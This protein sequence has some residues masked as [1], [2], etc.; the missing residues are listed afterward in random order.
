[1]RFLLEI[2]PEY[3]N[4]SMPFSTIR[5]NLI[6]TKQVEY[7][8]FFHLLQCVALTVLVHAYRKMAQLLPDTMLIFSPEQSDFF[9]F[10]LLQE[11]LFSVIFAQTDPLPFACHIL[12]TVHNA[13]A[14]K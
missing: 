11:Y 14:M 8:V 4:H 2:V 12:S 7:L 13:L 3:G 10:L 9:L 5:L 1:M 6:N